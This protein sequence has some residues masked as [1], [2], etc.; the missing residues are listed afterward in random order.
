MSCHMFPDGSIDELVRFAVRIG[1]KEKWLQKGRRGL[2]H[3]D[4][5]KSRREAAIKAGAIPLSREEAVKMWRR[6]RI[7]ERGERG[8]QDLP[9]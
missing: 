5:T 8:V 2:V 4:L 6:M 3:F 1:M 7:Y 9:V